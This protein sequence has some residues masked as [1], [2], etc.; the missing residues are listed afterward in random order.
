MTFEQL[1][2]LDAI[3]QYHS[4]QKAADALHKTQPALSIAIKK[5]EEELQV[6]IIDR[7]GYR[8]ALTNCGKHLYNQAKLILRQKEKLQSM[9]QH[10]A[11]GNETVLNVSFSKVI[12]TTALFKCL[13]ETQNQFPSVDYHILN[14]FGVGS[15]KELQQQ[16]CDIA[17]SP[18]L[19]SF[20]YMGD[21]E[22]KHYATLKFKP[23]ISYALYQ[24]FE[25]IPNSTTDLLNIPHIIP[26]NLEMDL[27]SDVVLR[28]AGEK[29]I[30]VNDVT[31][32]KNMI[33]DDMGWAILPE[34]L[35]KEELANKQM[36]ILNL[37]ENQSDVII[38][39]RA[40]KL[41]NKSLGPVA[42]HLW[43]AL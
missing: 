38:E 39:V 24:E 16:R 17:I 42:Q 6:K 31:I 15:I 27:D 23:V 37:Q 43:D 41:A 18:W 8:L 32:L 40:I 21:F 11:K 33:L 25:E 26:I 7:S 4:L 13:K 34:H 12:N 2:I 3:A 35:I 14:D 5:L 30:K 36:K 10:F 22:T 19:P 1:K 28:H 9:A 29:V 20:Q